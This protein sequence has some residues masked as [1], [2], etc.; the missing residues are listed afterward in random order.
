MT[1]DEITMLVD[2]LFNASAELEKLR[3]EAADYRAIIEERCRELGSETERADGLLVECER[4]RAELAKSK[5]ETFDAVASYSKR[6][7]D[8]QALR[9]EDERTIEKLRAAL[10]RIRRTAH[11][12]GSWALAKDVL[13]EVESIEREAGDAAANTGRAHGAK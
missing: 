10:E 11:T 7:A 1:I 6:L 9:R 13:I 4:L 2:G 8:E 5:R 12:L 3:A